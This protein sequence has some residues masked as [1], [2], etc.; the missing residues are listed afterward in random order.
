MSLNSAPSLLRCHAKYSESTQGFT[1]LLTSSILH[2]IPPTRINLANTTDQNA[3]NLAQHHTAPGAADQ[4]A[5]ETHLPDQQQ[6]VQG[7]LAQPQP[8]TQDAMPPAAFQELPLKQLTSEQLKQRCEARFLHLARCIENVCMDAMS[9]EWEWQKRVG[10]RARELWDCAEVVISEAMDTVAHCVA[11]VEAANERRDEVRREN[12]VLRRRVGEKERKVHSVKAK[13]SDELKRHVATLN[14]KWRKER[15]QLEAVRAHLEECSKRLDTE[16]PGSPIKQAQEELL[17]QQQMTKRVE[18]ERERLRVALEELRRQYTHV[19]LTLE[20]R[21]A[22]VEHV[23][24]IHQQTKAALREAESQNAQLNE[25]LHMAE[26]DLAAHKLRGQVDRL[27]VDA[28]ERTLSPFLGAKLPV[29]QPDLLGAAF[30]PAGS[31]I[32]QGPSGPGFSFYSR[33]SIVKF[34]APQAASPSSRDGGGQD[35]DATSLPYAHERRSTR[36]STLPAKSS[37]A[38]MLPQAA[39]STAEL[40]D[41]SARG[42]IT[43]SAVTESTNVREGVGEVDWWHEERKEKEEGADTTGKSAGEKVMS[44]FQRLKGVRQTA[45]KWKMRS[46]V[47]NPVKVLCRMTAIRPVPLDWLKERNIEAGRLVEMEEFCAEF[48]QAMASARGETDLDLLKSPVDPPPDDLRQPPPPIDLL[49]GLFPPTRGSRMSRSGITDGGGGG[50]PLLSLDRVRATVRVLLDAMTMDVFLSTTDFRA[51]PPFTEYVMAWLQRYDVNIS[52]SGTTAAPAVPGR[53]ADEVT[54]QV[55]IVERKG[56]GAASLAVGGGDRREGMTL[57]DTRATEVFVRSVLT[58]RERGGWEVHTFASFLL[59]EYSSDVLL[60]YLLIRHHL[61]GLE[62]RRKDDLTA[63]AKLVDV[64]QAIRWARTLLGSDSFTHREI[65]TLSEKLM[66]AAVRFGVSS[67]VKKTSEEDTEDDSSPTGSSTG[68]KEGTQKTKHQLPVYLLLRLF[69]DEF[70]V[71]R[72]KRLFC[73]KWLSELALTMRGGSFGGAAAAAAATAGPTATDRLSQAPSALLSR[74]GTKPLSGSASFRRATTMRSSTL[75]GQRK[76]RDLSEVLADSGSEEDEHDKDEGGTGVAAMAA[77][78][79][80][81]GGFS[82]SLTL[83]QVC[84]IVAALYPLPPETAPYTPLSIAARV[85]R[86]AATLGRGRVD[87]QSLACAVEALCLPSLSVKWHL[88]KQ[89]LTRPESGILV[90]AAASQASPDDVIKLVQDEYE[91]LQR[92]TVLG[93][94]PN[95]Y[96]MQL[97]ALTCLPNIMAALQPPMESRDSLGTED[98]TLTDL[99]LFRL[100]SVTFSLA[101][102]VSL[103]RLTATFDRPPASPLMVRKGGAGAP[104]GV[105]VGNREMARLRGVFSLLSE[106]LKLE[107]DIVS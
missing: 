24:D 54:S 41:D 9:A 80:D 85:F 82:P 58:Y 59:D 39:F 4:P 93:P 15:A 61:M 42:L 91:R 25:C 10:D 97:G 8:H 17:D 104:G 43:K 78:D 5:S 77:D 22:E 105:L 83:S 65:N 56:A 18:E 31:P 53:R 32:R 106:I 88:D 12:D 20:G 45:L 37:A 69:L 30:S 62:V 28:F 79:T 63:E 6:R 46:I 23:L 19:E 13:T 7:G 73:L 86:E 48:R 84:V 3:L 70:R 64:K 102:A 101:R 1:P 51:L 87:T 33:V 107:L 67:A 26:E 50:A 44:I 52:T 27:K 98:T 38:V 2:T 92:L 90:P 100:L 11:R 16:H 74:S 81:G 60:Y 57:G 72:H 99:S 21:E 68:D 94:R 35:R 49:L 66:S 103:A 47:K 89:G 55:W 29:L 14:C 76:T 96:I 36:G 34:A 40:V 75:S 95:A 71:E